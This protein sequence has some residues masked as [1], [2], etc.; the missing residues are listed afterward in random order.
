MINDYEICAECQVCADTTRVTALSVMSRKQLYGIALGLERRAAELR[1]Y[2]ECPDRE[3]THGRPHAA[4]H[5][6]PHLKVLPAA[7]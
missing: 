4:S 3:V 2:A 6:A 7:L 1:L 5:E